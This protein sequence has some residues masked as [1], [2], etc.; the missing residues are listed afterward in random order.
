MTSSSREIILA[1]SPDGP[2]T[3]YDTFTGTNLAGFSGSR[4]PRK[5]LALA[6]K[7]L[8]AAS[9]ISSATGSGSICLYNWWS[10]AAFYHILTPE[11][12]APLAVTPEGLY[13][14]SGG[15]S[16]HIH[17]FSLPSGNVLRSF[18]AHCKPVTCLVI[19]DDASLLIS[20]GDDGTIIIFPILRLLDASSKE[21]SARL[22]LYEIS[23]HTLSVTDITTTMGGCNS[24][25]ISCSL[26]S[27]C[28]FWSLAN[29]N[30]VRTVCFPC[31]IW[32]LVVDPT[33]SEFYA[34]GSDGR[35][36][37]GALKVGRR[38]CANTGAEVAPWI[39]EHGGMVTAVEM[40]N[41][42][43]NLVSASED[44]CIRVW[45]VEGGR[46]VRVVG[47]GR[48][49][50]SDLVVAKGVGGGGGGGENIVFGGQNMGFSGR[51]ICRPVREV[52]EMEEWLG[53]VVKDRSRAI[54]TLEASIGTYEKLLGLF[55]KEAKGG[56]IQE[57]EDTSSCP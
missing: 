47:Q 56:R 4:S 34:G 48:G 35:V 3:A 43:R 8:I 17:A 21:N 24:T 29:G 20:G 11:P 30:H 31:V 1:S 22:S 51:E 2:I 39:P 57:P 52:G 9:H 5:G 12:V 16:G 44:G 33:E 55:L 42:G 14:F 46:V 10:S 7:T 23:A 15:L 40:A 36:Y 32:C 50:I 53:V 27:T 37:V 19:N 6:G 54:D 18:P 25:I 28:K 49:G 38:Q 26:D 41:Q 45:E 13:L